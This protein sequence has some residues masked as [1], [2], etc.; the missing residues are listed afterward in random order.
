MSEIKVERM[1]YEQ[2]QSEKVW[3]IYGLMGKVRV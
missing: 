2:K 3:K 1:Q